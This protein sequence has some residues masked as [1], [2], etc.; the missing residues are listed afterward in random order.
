MVESRHQNAGHS[1]NL[2]IINKFFDNASK[3]KY[4]ETTVTNQLCI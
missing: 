3:F 1:H 2:L 4:L